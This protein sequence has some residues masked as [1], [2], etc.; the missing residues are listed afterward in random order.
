MFLGVVFGNVV[1]RN[2]A[3]GEGK[4]SWALWDCWGHMV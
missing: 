4:C 3:Q 2:L 1:E